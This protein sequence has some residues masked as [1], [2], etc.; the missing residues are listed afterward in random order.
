MLILCLTLIS[1][2]IGIRDEGALYERSDYCSALFASKPHEQT[3]RGK[4]IGRT[5]RA[6]R[7]KHEGG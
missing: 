4:V 6:G 1:R 3:L 2:R 5:P 7:N